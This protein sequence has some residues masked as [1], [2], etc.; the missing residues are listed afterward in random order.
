MVISAI[1]NSILLIF[2]VLLIIRLN[3]FKFI[4][5][6]LKEPLFVFS[7]LFTLLFGFGVGIASTNFGALVRYKIPLIPFYFTTMYLIYKKT[8][9]KTR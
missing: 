7:V 9:I 8:T 3:P 5:E 1:E 4:R 2:T 6:N